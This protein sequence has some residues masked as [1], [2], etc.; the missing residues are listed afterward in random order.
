MKIPGWVDLQVNGYRGVDFSSPELTVESLARACKE[1]GQAG[2][3]AF[4]ATV[5]TSS[6]EIY[7]RNLAVMAELIESGR[8][9]G[10][11][12]GIHLE[13]PFLCP[14]DGARGAHN[15]RWIVPADTVYL[16]QLLNWAYG[17]VRMITIAA[18]QPGAEELAAYAA[19]KGITVSLG[20]HLAGAETLERLCWIGARA[21]TH[22][23]NGVPA[24]LHRHDNP[25]LAGL[26]EDGLW[27]MLIPD[28]HHLPPSLI[29]TILRTKG[30]ERCVVTSDASPLAG[31]APGQ[32][33][34][35]GNEA[36][37]EEGGKL[38]NPN[39]G[40]LVGSSATILDCMNCLAGLDLLSL[41][42][43]IQVGFFNPLQLIGMKPEFVKK[44]RPME[45]DED[46]RRFVLI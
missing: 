22:L 30:V 38:Y 33:R 25:I 46:S 15:R 3:T 11:L 31:M 16:E 28:G 26:G 24:M 41:G 12:L 20:H 37:L 39:T 40:Y 5:I 19:Q 36:V 23:G 8:Y 13:G 35:L 43:L 10:Q 34:T 7:Q 2:T 18:D 14:E 6:K 32:Y 45:Y 29:K 17:T 9:A 44:G 42:E 21:L 27:A 4:L 1:L